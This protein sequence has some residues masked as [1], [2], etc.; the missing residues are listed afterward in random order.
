M[1]VNPCRTHCWAGAAGSQRVGSFHQSSYFGGRSILLRSCGSNVNVENVRR[2]A[3]SV[4]AKGKRSF[5][6][7]RQPNKQQMPAMPK[8]DEGDDTPKFVLFI[9]TKNVVPSLLPHFFC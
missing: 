6:P 9:R 4:R 5:T 3:V 1:V 8:M 2:A 7:G